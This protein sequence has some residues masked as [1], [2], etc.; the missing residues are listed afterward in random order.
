MTKKICLILTFLLI[1]NNVKLEDESW[2]K[3]IE[4]DGVVLK[5]NEGIFENMM[6]KINYAIVLFYEDKDKQSEIVQNHY[7]LAAESIVQITPAVGVFKMKCSD[8]PRFCS[9]L[10]KEEIPFVIW[11][12]N[13]N[14]GMYKETK[15]KENFIN[16]C[17]KMVKF[18]TIKLLETKEDIIEFLMNNNYYRLL[19][20]FPRM[21]D[22]TSVNEEIYENSIPNSLLAKSGEFVFREISKKRI[23]RVYLPRLQ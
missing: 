4:F 9:E 20:V 19:V 17:E 21:S 22:E 14:F 3:E 7:R 1:F 12:N 5:I 6:K 8:N 16:F 18:S 15:D 11:I 13:N 23:E 2:M 10:K